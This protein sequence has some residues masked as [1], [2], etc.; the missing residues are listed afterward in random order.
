LKSVQL[1][2]IYWLYYWFLCFSIFWA[3]YIFSINLLM[4]EFLLANIFSPFYN[5]FTS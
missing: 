5:F 4:D 2:P 1:F 3:L